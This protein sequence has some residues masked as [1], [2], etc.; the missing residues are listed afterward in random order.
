MC[1]GINVREMLTGCC[2]GILW[3]VAGRAALGQALNFGLPIRIIKE[4]DGV[5]LLSPSQNPAIL[6]GGVSVICI[7]CPKSECETSLY[8]CEALGFHAFPYRQCKLKVGNQS[9]L[10]RTYRWSVLLNS[11]LLHLSSRSP[12]IAKDTFCTESNF[13]Q[14]VK[15]Y[16]LSF[17]TP[18]I[19]PCGSRQSLPILQMKVSSVGSMST[20]SP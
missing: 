11:P 19:Q 6:C 13:R 8:E 14:P 20:Q 18:R 5:A 7:T 9:A 12:A 10:W 4:W 2:W 3:W 16:P 17:V 1:L 15:H